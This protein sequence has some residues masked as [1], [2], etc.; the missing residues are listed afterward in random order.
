MGLVLV[1]DMYSFSKACLDACV[2]TC[3]NTCQTFAVLC[4]TSA[5]SG[6]FGACRE[7]DVGVLAQELTKVSLTESRRAMLPRTD[8]LSCT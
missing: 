2:R 6:P 4:L 8:C 5:E 3:S 7:T 1:H